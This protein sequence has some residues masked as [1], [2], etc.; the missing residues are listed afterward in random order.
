MSTRGA[1]AIV[2]PPTATWIRAGLC[3]AE[4]PSMVTPGRPTRASLRLTRSPSRATVKARCAGRPARLAITGTTLMIAPVRSTSACTEAAVADASTCADTSIAPET[5]ASPWWRPRSRSRAVRST[6]VLP[7]ERRTRPEGASRPLIPVPAPMRSAA[8]G[9]RR[10]I[11]ARSAPS[12]PLPASGSKARSICS[13]PR[14]VPRNASASV[15]RRTSARSSSLPA[16]RPSSVRPS[17]TPAGLAKPRACTAAAPPSR[18]SFPRRSSRGPCAS[19]LTTSGP[20]TVTPGGR[21]GGGR[22]SRS[23]SPGAVTSTASA[24]TEGSAPIPFSSASPRRA[25]SPTWRAASATFRVPVDRVKVS[26][27]SRLTPAGCPSTILPA[28]SVSRRHTSPTA[29]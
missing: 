15:P 12:R 17:G 21:R 20:R 22:S 4:S 18:A 27:A 14:T 1:S 7:P 13:G 10:S 29:S 3:S 16:T 2:A 25:S 26:A 6:V 24:S 19:S 23:A 8:S 9:K 11:V 5:P 28:R